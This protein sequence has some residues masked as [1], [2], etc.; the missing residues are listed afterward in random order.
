[1]HDVDAFVAQIRH[2]L[3]T[4]INAILGYSQL[5]LEEGDQFS[6]GVAERSHLAIVA[7]SGKQLLRIFS[8]ILDPA[9]FTDGIE[10]YAYRLRYTTR[11]QIS[12]VR[13]CI[14]TLLKEHESTPMADDLRRIRAAAVRLSEI[15]DNVEHTFRVR[16]TVT[17]DTPPPRTE[18]A[19][20]FAVTGDAASCG[21]SILVIDDEEANRALLARRLIRQGYC[22]LFAETGEAGLAIA[23]R[24][25]VDVILLDVMLPGMSGYDVLARLKRDEALREVPVLILTAVDGT[26]SVT[27]CLA[28]G[29][30]DYLAKPFDPAV[31]GTRVRA[32]L[33]KKRA[34]DL[35]LAY[36][37]GV[38][39]VTAAALAVESGNF[40]PGSLDDIAQRPD[41]LGNLAR[42]FQHMAIEVAARQRRLE[43]QVQ[44]LT[45]AIDEKKKA[46][47][48]NE[49]TDSDY[50]RD[51][52]ARARHFA[53]RRATRS[54][55]SH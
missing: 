19:E 22:V 11:P 53:A 2:E 20:A 32:C 43:E 33:A 35:D 30:D 50:F 55:D 34:R 7:D 25:L 42:L 51:L 29:A 12:K 28:L 40:T 37:R 49:I 23:A 8:E 41:P 45:I 10:E 31:L 52:Q 17:V 21:G 24:E 48:V 13:G 16:V 3:K 9:G 38:A 14:Q 47:E 6:L 44:R 4:P 26:E 5:L 15:I 39:K 27:R 36:L 18:S 1:M 54:G 46:A